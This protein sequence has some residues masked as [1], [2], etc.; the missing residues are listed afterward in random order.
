M[1]KGEGSECINSPKWQGFPKL[2][3]KARFSFFQ[4]GYSSPVKSVVLPET[5]TGW[6]CEKSILFLLKHER[7][8]LWKAICQAWIY[9]T[10]FFFSSVLLRSHQNHW[11]PGRGEFP[12]QAANPNQGKESML[13]S[14]GT[15]PHP[16]CLL[17]EAQ[18]GRSWE[19]CLEGWPQ[20]SELE[21]RQKSP[22]WQPP[23]KIITAHFHSLWSRIRDSFRK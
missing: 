5:L 4:F 13:R 8:F 3:L 10:S 23:L 2:G 22:A 20:G 6:A 17:P 9:F 19:A 16:P 1:H 15:T 7:T 11:N 12:P 21:R 18:A 14:A